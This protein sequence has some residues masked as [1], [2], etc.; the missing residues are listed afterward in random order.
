[1]EISLNGQRSKINYLEF[2]LVRTERKFEW[3]Y[4]RLGISLKGN[5]FELPKVKHK[6]VGVQTSSNRYKFEQIFQTEFDWAHGW[7]RWFGLGAL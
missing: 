3:Q 2:K 7:V 6:L 1:M 5:K 4:V